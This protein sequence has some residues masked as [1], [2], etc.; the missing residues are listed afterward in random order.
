MM[1]KVAIVGIG[2][3]KFER[4]KKEQA[5]AE[6]V[7]E[8]VTKALEDAGI[9]IAEIDNIVTISNDFWDGRTI[10]SMAVT[11]A[12]GAYGKDMTTVEGDGTFGALLGYMRTLS[13]SFDTTLV[14]AHSKISEGNPR[15]IFNC[16]FDPIYE[17]MLGLD[18]ITSSALQA[19]RYMAKYGVTEAQSAKVSVKNHKNAKNNPYAQL[20]LDIK[21]E[22]VLNSRMLADPIKV[23]DTSPISDGACAIILANEWKVK[24]NSEKP[25]WIK[26]VGHCADAYHLGDRD[27]AETDSLKEAAN[28]AYKMAG[29]KVP[30]KDIDVAEVYDA[31]SYQELMWLE[32]L[33]FCKKGEGG[34][35]IDEGVTEMSGELPVN[36]S[37]GVLSAHAV[38]VA[39]LVRIA[40]A[41]LQ[42][43]GDAGKRQLSNIN[44]ALAHG[45]NGPCGQSHCVWILG[46]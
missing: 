23:L 37:G 46:R 34:K 45:I 39:G 19:R 43:R 40:E 7:Y 42:I 18:A 5:F 29:V 16:A 36:P 22:D 12:C 27:L 32:G 35:L 38:L 11:D 30:I 3:T 8:V 13:G 44:M 25:V 26:G 33:G 4:E 6:L 20:P 14:V 31:F 28:K 9:T 10:S 41:A 21:V 2:Q 24:K 17:R 1:E 15:A